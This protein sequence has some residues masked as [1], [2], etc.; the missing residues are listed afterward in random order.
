MARKGYKVITIKEET[1][2]RVVKVANLLGVSPPD[3]V[4]LLAGYALASPS[5]LEQIKKEKLA[6]GS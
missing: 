4:D 6:G 1:H 3:A 5:N 2:T